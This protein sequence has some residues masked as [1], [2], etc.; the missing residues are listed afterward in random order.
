MVVAVTTCDSRPAE[1]CL[2]CSEEPF[3]D[4]LNVLLLHLVRRGYKLQERT[5]GYQNTSGWGSQSRKRGS[6]ISSE[7]GKKSRETR[8]RKALRS[9]MQLL[10]ITSPIINNVPKVVTYWGQT[11]LGELAKV[12]SFPQRHEWSRS[13]HETVRMERRGG[14]KTA[15]QDLVISEQGI[16][17]KRQETGTWV[18]LNQI[19]GH[20]QAHSDRHIPYSTLVMA[21]YGL[22]LQ[23]AILKL[24][25]GSTSHFPPLSW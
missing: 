6:F 23:E 21:T 24:Q 2:K 7:R 20:R 3:A 4:E 8:W 1:H 10:N 17:H 18:L 19:P 13:A 15:A 16:L 22:N 25:P 14:V 11:F 12:P 5:H 9:G